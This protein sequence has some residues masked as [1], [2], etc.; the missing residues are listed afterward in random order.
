MLACVWLHWVLLLARGWLELA[1]AEGDGVAN[2]DA[3][4]DTRKP[5]GFVLALCCAVLSH[6]VGGL[7][8]WELRN[9][10]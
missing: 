5:V 8:G 9:A 4:T 7:G 1:V 10:D 3:Y 6:W 2:L